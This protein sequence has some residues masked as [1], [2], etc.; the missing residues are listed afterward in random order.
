MQRSALCMNRLPP[1]LFCL[2]HRRRRRTSC[3]KRC[4]LQVRT[5]RRIARFGMEAAERDGSDAVD[6]GQSHLTG[7]HRQPPGTEPC[8][9]L[10]RKLQRH[11]TNSHRRV[12]SRA[13]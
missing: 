11:A 5:T 10:R 6:G 8:G 2:L 7:D 13:V 9:F 3:L 1:L 4:Y 12:V